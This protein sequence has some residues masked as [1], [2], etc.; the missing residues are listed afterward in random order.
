MEESEALYGECHFRVARPERR[1]MDGLCTLQ[2]RLGVVVK[3]LA[4]ENEGEGVERPGDVG[5][6]FAEEALAECERLLGGC[7]GLGVLALRR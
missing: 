1:L 3:A 4:L 5:M 6:L 2:Q 7:N